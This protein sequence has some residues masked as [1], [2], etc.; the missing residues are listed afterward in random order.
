MFWRSNISE[1][2]LPLVC[3]WDEGFWANPTQTCGHHKLLKAHCLF[4]LPVLIFA[5]C[6]GGP[7]GEGKGNIAF[8]S[9]ILQIVWLRVRGYYLFTQCLRVAC[10]LFEVSRLI[11][12][13]A[14]RIKV[15]GMGLF[16]IQSHNP[17][18]REQSPTPRVEVE[19]VQ[20][21]R[22]RLGNRGC[23]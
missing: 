19:I 8:A 22:R 21:R 14:E 6:N 18:M 15:L 11:F 7:G 20:T 23:M 16:M 3:F 2:L 9:S 17:P 12:C 10:I 4:C 5:L 1:T 13:V